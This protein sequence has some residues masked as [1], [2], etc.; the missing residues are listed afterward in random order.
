MASW[1][2]QLAILGICALVAVLVAPAAAKRPSKEEVI[3]EVKSA[4]D[5]L[6]NPAISS[7]YRIT[8]TFLDHFIPKLGK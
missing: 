2:N 4:R 7:K 6:K 1:W 3:A 8:T 5:A